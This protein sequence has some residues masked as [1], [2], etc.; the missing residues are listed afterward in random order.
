MRSDDYRRQW[1]CEFHE[2]APNKVNW[3]SFI[4]SFLLRIGGRS[5]FNYHYGSDLPIQIVPGNSLPDLQYS[6]NLSTRTTLII[7]GA[8]WLKENLTPEQ[9]AEYVVDRM[10]GKMQKGGNI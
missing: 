1:K 9:F 5:Y 2:A 4:R 7:V 8:D 3:K 10:E 6:C